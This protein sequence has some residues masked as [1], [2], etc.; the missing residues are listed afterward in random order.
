MKSDLLNQVLHAK[1]GFDHFRP[2]Q[3][4]TLQ[5]VMDKQPTLAVLPTGSGKSLLFQLPAYLLPGLILVVSPLISL[6][7]DQVDRL[8]AQGHFKVA[9]LNSSLSYADRQALLSNIGH[10]RFLFTSPESLA[11]PA[12][13]G[14]LK[15]LSISMF[16]V[17]E[18]HCVSQWGPDFRP[19]YL[20]LKQTIKRLRPERLLMLTA[21][22]TPTVCQD[23]VAKLGLE[24][25]TVKVVKRSVDRQNI[26]LAVQTLADEDK[27]K[28]RLLSLL[29]ALKTSG[30]VYFSS[31]KLADELAAWVRAHSQLKVSSYHAGQ[32]RRERFIIQQQFMQ[33]QLD[34]IFATS[35]FGMGIDKGNLRFVIHYHL[36]ASLESYWQEIGRAGRDGQPAIAILLYC[37]GD[38]SLPEMLMTPELPTSDAV[39]NWQRHRNQSAIL[40]PQGE[41]VAFYL[42]HGWS[43]NQ[44]QKLFDQQLQ[45]G[46]AR[47]RKMLGYVHSST[48]RRNYVL[49]YFGQ[50]ATKPLHSCCD[51]DQPDW[52]I[53]K[54]KLP[55]EKPAAEVA[56][57][58]WQ[59]RLRTLMGLSS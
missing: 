19:E 39:L 18:A 31:R 7:Q 49:N 42:Q 41:V 56:H 11:N 17:D 23:I 38:E 55:T 25:S 35:A 54:L 37:P 8:R 36:P 57:D 27:K 9:M 33:G 51:V 15:R 47:L 10:F 58:D 21:T 29:Q 26:F 14:L 53:E 12:V 2:G 44:I 28:A 20:L 43:L 59:E 3:K 52:T 22:A 5:A 46:Q 40:G 30:V 48:C 24:P 6:M 4:E 45:R 50:S 16:V 34:V 1:F 32:T 13:Q